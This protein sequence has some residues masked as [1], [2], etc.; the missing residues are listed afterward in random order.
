MTRQELSDEQAR[1]ILATAIR[2]HYAT[3]GAIFQPWDGFELRWQGGEL[4]RVADG[5][6]VIEGPN[7][8]YDMTD[9]DIECAVFGLPRPKTSK[10]AR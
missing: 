1:A 2:N 5:V 4:I 6:K 7:A 3:K 9:E 8:I 10:G